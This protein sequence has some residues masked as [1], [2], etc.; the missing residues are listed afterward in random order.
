MDSGGHRDLPGRGDNPIHSEVV[1]AV[2]T[3][4]THQFRS[5]A[6]LGLLPTTTLDVEEERPPGTHRQGRAEQLDL[7]LC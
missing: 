2:G 4:L 3:S 7:D 6:W 1:L 5:L